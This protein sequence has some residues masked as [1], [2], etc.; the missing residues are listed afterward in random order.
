MAKAR[1]TKKS[2]TIPILE[3]VSAHIA[4]NL[5]CNGGIQCDRCYWMARQCSSIILAVWPRQHHPLVENRVKK[6]QEK[7]IT[8]R[9]VSSAEC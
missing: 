6:I 9:H 7:Q 8:W 4:A 2:M 3:L 5:V 1:L